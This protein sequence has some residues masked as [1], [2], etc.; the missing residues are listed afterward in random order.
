[1]KRIIFLFSFLTFHILLYLCTAFRVE[2]SMI[3]GQWSIKEK[4]SG[5]SA[6][7]SAPGLGPG[8]RPFESGHPDFFCK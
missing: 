6:V 5:C 2:W 7:G 1:M 3:Y 4:Q 8:G